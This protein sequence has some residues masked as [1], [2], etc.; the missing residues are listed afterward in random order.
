MIPSEIHLHNN[1]NANLFYSENGLQL[2]EG[3]MRN[4][5]YDKHGNYIDFF[6]ADYKDS[7]GKEIIEHLSENEPIELIQDTSYPYDQFAISV[8]SSDPI[9]LGYVPDII[10]PLI[11]HKLDDKNKKVNAIIKKIKLN[12]HDE[13][14]IEIRVFVDKVKK[15]S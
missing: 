15:F 11:S 1:N 2:I 10:S 7:D 13:C 3:T 12:A 8:W 9:Q 6:V 5:I 4:D 14:K